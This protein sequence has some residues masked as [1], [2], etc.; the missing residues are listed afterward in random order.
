MKIIALSVPGP[1]PDP[2]KMDELAREEARNAS[3]LLKAGR[4]ARGLPKEGQTGGNCRAGGINWGSGGTGTIPTSVLS[5]WTYPLR[6][7]TRRA[8]YQL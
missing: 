4:C 1:T 5:A 8:I 6:P 3:E 2:K 7:D